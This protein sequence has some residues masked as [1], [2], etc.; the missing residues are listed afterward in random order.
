NAERGAKIVGRSIEETQQTSTIVITEQ[1]RRTVRSGDVHQVVQ[2]QAELLIEHG[3]Y[4]RFGIRK[5]H[6]QVQVKIRRVAM[7][8]T[9]LLKIDAVRLHVSRQLREQD[10]NPSVPPPCRLF[11]LRHEH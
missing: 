5:Q 7:V 2:Q 9:R 6:A 4:R 11:E 8:V 10:L 1:R 3:R